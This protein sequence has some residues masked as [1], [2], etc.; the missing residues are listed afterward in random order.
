[1][2]SLAAVHAARSETIRALQLDELDFRQGRIT[3]DGNV[4]PMGP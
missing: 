2:G 3:I 1:M 4:Q